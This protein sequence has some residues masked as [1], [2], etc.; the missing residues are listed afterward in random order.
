MYSAL[1]FLLIYLILNVLLWR[2]DVLTG[3]LPDRF[4]CPLLWGGLLYH[5]FCIPDRLPDA[6]WGA[7]AGYAG[8][9]FIYWGYW[10]LRRREGLG[11]GDVKFLAALG[12]WHCWE[13]LPALVFL[14]ALLGCGGTAVRFA[15]GRKE[16]LKNPLPF[17]P[18]LAA[19]G[20][21]I[22]WLRLTPAG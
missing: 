20:L 13:P 17:G 21:F 11:Y 16:A 1:P 8:F 5:L 7:V 12:A 2:H 22:G 19:A 18:Y 10:L 4:T 15:T 14:A 6:V 3:S 9:A